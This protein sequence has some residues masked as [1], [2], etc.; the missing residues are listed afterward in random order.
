VIVMF[1]CVL[2]LSGADGS[3][4]GSSATELRHALHI[5]NTDIGLLVAVSSVVGA[6]AS[7]P[8]GV[9][10]DRFNRTR[11]LG[12]AVGFWGLVMIYSA[13]VSSFD[14]LLLARLFLGFGTAAAGPVVASLVGDYFGASERGRIYGYILTG[15][16]LGTGLGFAVTGDI[17]ALSWRAAFVILAIPAFVLARLVLRLPEPQRGGHNPL[18]VVGAEGRVVSGDAS[19]TLASEGAAAFAAA[20]S[21]PAPT[22]A[23][24]LAVRAGIAPDP[25]RILRGDLRR[26]NLLAAVRAVLG[27]RTNIILVVSSACG[28]FYMAGVSTFGAEYVRQQFRINQAFANL[29][30]L[31]VGFGAVLGVFF[32]GRLSDGLLRRG[33]LRSRVLVAGLSVLGASVLFIPAL[34]TRSVMSAVPYLTFAAMLLAAQNP[35][36]DAARLDIMPPLLW[37]RAEG[38]R[39]TLRTASQALAP[40]I[41]GFLA[42]TVFGGGRVGLQRAFAVMLIALVASGVILLR[43][44]RSYPRDVAT[45]AASAAS[46][47]SGQSTTGPYSP[48]TRIPQQGPV[49]SPAELGGGHSAGGWGGAV[50]G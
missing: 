38:I 5:G 1:A 41:F 3:T 10:A 49:P 40:V 44:L 22:D 32:A 11:T 28:Y 37:G 33:F 39:T 19:D 35:P 15:E 12:L 26:M 30:L 18:P 50:R 27:V 34:L 42:D 17:A 2:G 21:A 4:V 23:Q 24:K 14:R 48:T 7:L 6:V 13:T 31:V 45:A 36:I 29:L 46:E 25:E 47:P 43:G 9:I 16:L 8:F 20:S